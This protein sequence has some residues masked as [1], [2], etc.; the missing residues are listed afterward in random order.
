MLSLQS[1]GNAGSHVGSGC[2]C[3]GDQVGGVLKLMSGGRG[4][5]RSR[6]GRREAGQM[7]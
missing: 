1:M 4:S 6:D 3:R 7:S 5:G 2:G